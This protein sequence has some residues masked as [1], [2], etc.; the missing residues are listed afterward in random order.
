[1]AP[2]LLQVVAGCSI[3]LT[4]PGCGGGGGGGGGG[5][6]TDTALRI[7]HAAVGLAPLEAHVGEGLIQAAKYADVT[8]FAEVAQGPQNVILRRANTPD[9]T[10]RSINV[11]FAEETEYTIFV[12]GGA[13]LDSDNVTVLNEP[14]EQPA[15]GSARIQFLN[16][17]ESG[18]RIDVTGG[19]LTEALGAQFG[20]GSG[21]RTIASGPQDFVLTQGGGQF[22][23]VSVTVPDQGEVTIVAS[24]SEDLAFNQV[25]V[26]TDLD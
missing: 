3:L 18:R 24:G 1:M 19:T 15:A 4:M 9:S 26:Y 20:A 12:Y 25:R 21:F 5:R 10:F 23:R 17:Y 13:Y 2:R 6:T 8:E 7:V 22:A 14:V 16:G 11:D